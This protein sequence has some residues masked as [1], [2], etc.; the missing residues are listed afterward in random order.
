MDY[1]LPKYF[2]IKRSILVML[3]SGELGENSLLPSERELMQNYNVSRI[4][5][6]KAIQELEQEGF[7]YKVQGKGTFVR[8]EHKKQDLISI[9]S[10]TED[11]KR[12]G[13]TPSRKVLYKQIILADKK[14]Q[15]RLCLAEGENVFCMSRVYFADGE[16]INYTTVYLPYKLFKGIEL[17]DFEKYS[18]YGV[19]ENDYSIKITRAERTLEAVLSY[20][21]ICKELNIHAG[22]PLILFQCI[23][24]GEIK[25]K[26]IPIETFKCFYRSDKFKF[27]INQV[28]KEKFDK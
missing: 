4:T 18:L 20:G 23:T 12:Q 11:V 25:G 2:T 6:R 10:C 14:R 27:C 8:G 26:E 28:R 9:T 17:Y 21:D 5:V 22:I 15:S 13:M 7:V 19:I 16:P 1:T 3:D 24:Y